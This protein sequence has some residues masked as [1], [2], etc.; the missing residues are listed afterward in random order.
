MWPSVNIVR[1][2]V[3]V[4]SGA[5]LVLSGLHASVRSDKTDETG[6]TL[7]VWYILGTSCNLRTVEA[8]TQN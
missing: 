3:D 5:G 8:L 2:F 4:T 1:S 7:I 6:E